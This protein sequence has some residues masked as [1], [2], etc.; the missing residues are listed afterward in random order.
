MNEL[1][2]AASNYSGCNLLLLLWIA[3]RQKVHFF[4]LMFIL[5]IFSSAIITAL[6]VFVVLYLRFKSNHDIVAANIVR[7]AARHFKKLKMQ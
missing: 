2:L 1:C 4:F 7:T 5:L 3:I 6:V